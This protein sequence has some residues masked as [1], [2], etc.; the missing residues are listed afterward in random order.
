MIVRWFIAWLITQA[1]EVPLYLRVTSWRVA[2]LASTFTH[3]IVWFVFL[4][5]GPAGT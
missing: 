2:A 1:I 3:P 4:N 5:T